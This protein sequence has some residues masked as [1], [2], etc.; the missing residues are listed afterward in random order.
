MSIAQAITNK[1]ATTTG[2]SSLIGTRLYPSYDREA[3][4]QYP[5]AVYKIQNTTAQM[6][7]DGPTGLESADCVIAAIGKSY[8]DADTAAQAI[9]AALNGARGTWN[10]V[11]VQGTFAKDGE[12]GND[13]VVT[14]ATSEE[15]TLYTKTLTFEVWYAAQ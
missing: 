1:L 6:S 15:I 5:L 10:G 7:T 3:D 4:H 14:E 11:I 9:K 2:V 13:D 8:A 12:A